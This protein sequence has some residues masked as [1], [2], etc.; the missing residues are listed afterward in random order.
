MQKREH[1]FGKHQTVEPTLDGSSDFYEWEM[2]NRFFHI[3]SAYIYLRL[4]QWSGPIYPPSPTRSNPRS[5]GDPNQ[6]SRT[7]HEVE[8]RRNIFF[9][10]IAFLMLWAEA[11]PRKPSSPTRRTV[12]VM[13]QTLKP[14]GHASRRD[15][16]EWTRPRSRP[17]IL[18]N[19]PRGL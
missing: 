7:A 2:R 8:R 19:R 10:S 9:Q 15:E 4:S 12:G 6:L 14:K 17:C 1:Q 3:Q 11:K 18:K 5:E 16:H 13:P